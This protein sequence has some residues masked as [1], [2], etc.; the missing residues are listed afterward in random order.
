[1]VAEVRHTQQQPGYFQEETRQLWSWRGCVL[2]SISPAV[3]RCAEIGID[4]QYT[5]TVH[6]DD[7]SGTTVYQASKQAAQGGM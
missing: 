2:D 3:S 6:Q 4:S 1:M 7:R 5:V